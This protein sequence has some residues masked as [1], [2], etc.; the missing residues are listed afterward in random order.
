[1]KKTHMKLL[2]K[3]M[4]KEGKNK[5]KDVSYLTDVMKIISALNWTYFLIHVMATYCNSKFFF[6]FKKSLL[7]KT[8]DINLIIYDN[9]K[10]EFIQ[11]ESKLFLI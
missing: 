11:N 6:V 9:L 5:D 2:K 1:M 7:E 8:I 4:M 10:C 3:I